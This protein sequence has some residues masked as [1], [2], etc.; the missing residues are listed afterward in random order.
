MTT[1]LVLALTVGVLWAAVGALFGYAPVE[2]DRLISFFALNSTIYFLFSTFSLSL[3]AKGGELWILALLMVPAAVAELAG[4]WVLK[5]AMNQ[6][7]QGIAWA[8]IQSSMVIPFLGALFLPGNSATVIQLVGIVLLFA[9][10]GCLAGEKQRRNRPSKFGSEHSFARLLAAAFLLVGISQFLRLLPNYF[11]LSEETLSWR[12]FFSA[13]T[14]LVWW[15]VWAAARKKYLLRSVWQVA[16]CYGLTVALGQFVFYRAADAAAA[17][18]W[19]SGVIPTAVGSSIILF[20]VYCSVFRR[21]R[22][23]VL[24]WTGIFLIVA[25]IAGL[26]R[27]C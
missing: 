10:V 13:L 27:P 22:G 21:E 15:N 7:S 14:G 17:C 2:K 24:G 3:P 6:G 19:S 26:S 9:G 16:L 1:A 8:I 4:F 5:Q 25:G 23:A 18:G 12:L 20:C 11:P